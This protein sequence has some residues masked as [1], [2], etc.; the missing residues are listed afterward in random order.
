MFSLFNFSSIFPGGSADPICPYMRTPT[1]KPT[2]NIQNET[3]LVRERIRRGANVHSGVVDFGV[4]YFQSTA[5]WRRRRRRNGEAC[6][7]SVNELV[8]VVDDSRFV[9]AGNAAEVPSYVRVGVGCASE[10]RRRPD[11]DTGVWRI[12]RY[13]SPSKRTRTTRYDTIR[14]AILT[15]AQ[16]LTSPDSA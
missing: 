14:G 16:K 9:A 10:R 7:K 2:W 8:S 6:A 4:G 11:D 3:S 5:T 13:S 1:W 12:R 15:C